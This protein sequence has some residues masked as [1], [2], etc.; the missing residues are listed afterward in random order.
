MYVLVPLLPVAFA[1]F[2][3]SVAYEGEIYL[4]NIKGSIKKLFKS[5]YLENYLGKEYLRSLFLGTSEEDEKE[6]LFALINKDGDKADCP[7]F[8]KDYAAQVHLLKNFGHKQLNA[9]SAKR[10]KVILK[11]LND[12]EK[13]F[14]KEVFNPGKQQ[15]PYAKQLSLWLANHKQKEWQDRLKSRQFTFN[16]LKIF[17]GIAGIFMTLGSSYLIVEA[18]SVIPFMAGISF[19][20]WPVFIVPMAIIAGAAYGLLTYNAITDFVNNDTIKQWYKKLRDAWKEGFSWRNVFITSIAVFLVA[21]TIALTICTAGTWWTV[22]SNARPL[23]TWM[24]NMPKFIMSII[25]PIIIG[26]ST[27]SFIF[28]NIGETLELLDDATRS[29]KGD[30]L[31]RFEASLIEAF[32]HL[33]NTENIL[34]MLNP[35]RLILK[36]T[37]TPLRVLLFLGH[38]ISIGVTA[39][40]MR[41]VPEVVAALIA[42]ISEGFEDAHY[43]VGHD[44]EHQHEHDLKTLLKERLDP[45]ESHNHDLDIPT[46]FLK[47]LAS[48]IYLLATLWD[49]LSSKLNNSHRKVLDLTQ[50]L[51]KQLGIPEEQDVQ[52]DSATKQ[53]PD[54]QVEHTLF[55]IDKYKAKHL[56]GVVVGKDIAAEKSLGLDKLK[57]EV[58]STKDLA[59]TLKAAKNQ[60]VYNKHRWFTNPEETTS[61]KAFV[62]E[63]QDRIM[64]TCSA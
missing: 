57:E 16:G 35:F 3:L 45:A 40:R 48:P 9:Q 20:L 17:S 54:W 13:W 10:K 8:F 4:Q 59:S 18:F 34:Q 44:H 60:S 43:F 61:T 6:S 36:L 62:D 42:I 19:A 41:G 38:L 53:N 1:A 37:I 26:L 12:M 23:F 50:S 28:P 24:Q 49:C 30:L 51:Y 52:V 2:G 5:N 7:Q 27:I 33:R 39:D 56:S 22:A 47:V 11:N 64:G 21:I 58:Q 46:L 32:K 63:L 29:Y 31:E 15:S 14:A 25:N 55:A